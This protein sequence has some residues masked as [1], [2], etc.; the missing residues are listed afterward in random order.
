M[1]NEFLQ[2]FLGA[3]DDNFP[4]FFYFW[5]FRAVLA[6]LVLLALLVFGLYSVAVV[7]RAVSAWLRPRSDREV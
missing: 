2:L 4:N 3:Y 6:L 1:F 7:V 5:E